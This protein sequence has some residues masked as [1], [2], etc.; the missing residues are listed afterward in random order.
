MFIFYCKKCKT[1]KKLEKAILEIV[2]NS[3]VV[4]RD[5]ECDKCGD[6]MI[7]VQKEFGVPYLIRTE[8]TLK[9]K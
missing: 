8:P 9:K 5:S 4:T 1:E 6:Y 7:E 3:K 2:E